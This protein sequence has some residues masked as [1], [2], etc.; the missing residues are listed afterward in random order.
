MTHSK[1]AQDRSSVALVTGGSSGIGLELACCF[2]RDGY[3][4]VIAAQEQEKLD[5]A[6]E[7][8][9]GLGS[10]YVETIAVDLSHP[11]GAPRLFEQVE[12][13]GV[14]PEFLVLNAGVGVWGDFARMT[15]LYRE[16]RMIQLNVVSTVQAAK[17]FLPAMIERGSGR[18]LITSSLSAVGTAPK[19]TVYSATKAFLHAFAQGLRNEVA[20]SGVT[21][22][23][24]LPDITQTDFF[25]R[26]GAEDSD[27]IDAKKA[28]PAA[29]AHSGYAALM[30][31]SDHVVAPGM[32]KFKAAVASVLP[33][34]LVTQLARA[35]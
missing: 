8:L 14:E 25:R 28:N 1:V 27:T 2:A 30:K 26:A 18:I 31:G 24:L 7:T 23:S 11:D 34:R 4:L 35:E 20:D 13:L 16:L 29:V 19:L 3:A 9:R 17:I 15:D 12:K 6:A 33:D 22:T 10:P 32:S 21:V 5:K